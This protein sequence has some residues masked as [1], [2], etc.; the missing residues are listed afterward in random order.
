[1]QELMTEM[2]RRWTKIE[3]PEAYANFTVACRATDYLKLSSRVMVADGTDLVRLGQPLTL[4]LPDSVLLI[5]DQC[6]VVE[7]LSQLPP[8]QRAVFA[9]VYDGYD[10]ADIAAILK[11][12][13]ATV[14]SHLRHARTA[15]RAWWIS[16][17]K[18]NE[19]RGRP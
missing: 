8:L 19:E 14:R 2:Y 1:V 16:R 5:E 3:S 13:A 6:L 10:T 9:L 18:G 17:I 15:L 7:A 12:N 4:G 11:L